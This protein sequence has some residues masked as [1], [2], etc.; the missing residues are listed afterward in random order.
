MEQRTQPAFQLR[1]QA[2]LGKLPNEQE[3]KLPHDSSL[4]TEFMNLTAVCCPAQMGLSPW[5][6]FFF[7][8]SLSIPIEHHKPFRG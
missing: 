2:W 4:T 7:S 8:S 5:C 1:G 3:L 6:S